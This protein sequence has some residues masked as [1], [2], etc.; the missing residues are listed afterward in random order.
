MGDKE[1][2]ANLLFIIIILILMKKRRYLY[3][4][5]IIIPY[6]GITVNF[7]MTKRLLPRSPLKTKE[8][9]MFPVINQIPKFISSIVPGHVYETKDYDNI[10]L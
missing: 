7:I 4:K 3:L 6:F 8:N 10:S 9:K 5:S 2:T 1:G